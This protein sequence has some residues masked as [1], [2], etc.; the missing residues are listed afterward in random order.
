VVAAVAALGLCTARTGA[1]SDP[2]SARCVRP[3]FTFGAVAVSSD[4]R[5]VSVRF[6]CARATLAGTLFLRRGAGPHPAAVWVHGSGP[7][8]RL[9]FPKGVLPR[10]VRSGVAVL[11]WDKRG[12]GA[13]TGRCCPG[14]RG[15]FDLLA[16]DVD[17]A[18]NALRAYRDVDR[19]RVGIIGASQA[20]WIVPLAAVRFRHPIAFTAMVD[21]PAVSYGEENLYSKLTGEEGGMPSGLSAAEIERRLDEA[22][23]SG[24]DPRPYLA[25]MTSP[26]LWLY[27]G[28]DLSQRTGRSVTVLKHLKRSRAR[29]FTTRVFPQANHGLLDIPPTDPRALPVLVGWVNRHVD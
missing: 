25:R 3:P 27:G 26:G 14:D 21:A 15:H 7:A 18:L 11:S 13:S 22:G 4:H 12:V 5:E 1:A 20:G 24:F 28:K 29:R 17:G 6:R 16:A 9:R 8:R 23:P 19:R 10:L 2:E